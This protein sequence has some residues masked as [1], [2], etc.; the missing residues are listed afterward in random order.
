MLI[1]SFFLEQ[2]SVI[3]DSLALNVF[4]FSLGNHFKTFFI[5]IV[6]LD[7]SAEEPQKHMLSIPAELTHFNSSL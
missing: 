3:H 7:H 5:A 2:N 4:F 6:K 1:T